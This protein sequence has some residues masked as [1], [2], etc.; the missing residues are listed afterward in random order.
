M[1]T[2]PSERDP[3]EADDLNRI[4]KI[5]IGVAVAIWV[6][7]LVGVALVVVAVINIAA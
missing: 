1:V 3:N 6:A 4:R 7:A 5:S 2:D